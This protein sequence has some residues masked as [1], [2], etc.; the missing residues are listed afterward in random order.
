[1]NNFK[2]CIFRV[3]SA[4][5]ASA[6]RKANGSI[7]TASKLLGFDHHWK[8]A[9]LMKRHPETWSLRTPPMKRRQSVIRRVPTE[10]EGAWHREAL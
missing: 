6:L 1:M 7:S 9:A 2:D 5:I 4:L 8:L 10:R 3:E